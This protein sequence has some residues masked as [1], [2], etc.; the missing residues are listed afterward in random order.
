VT[1]EDR[2]FAPFPA[3]VRIRTST[4]ERIEETIRV[5]HWLDG[6]KSFEIEVP[7]GVGSVTRVE[8]DPSGYVPDV[9]RSNNFWP[10][11]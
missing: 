1:I 4:G 6:H 10:R 2:G 3:T 7:A 8:V 11:G 9:D 5:D